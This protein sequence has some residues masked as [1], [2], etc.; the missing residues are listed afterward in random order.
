MLAPMADR[1]YS[2][3]E[4]DRMRNAVRRQFP[5]SWGGLIGMP[6]TLSTEYDA[7]VE[8]RLRTFMLN[9]TEPDELDGGKPIGLGMFDTISTELKD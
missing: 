7:Q 3:Q 2:V 1:K 4:I 5:M 8:D 6:M 9:G